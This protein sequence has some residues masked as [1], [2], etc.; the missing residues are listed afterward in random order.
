[1][2]TVTLLEALVDQGHL[3]LHGAVRAPV[4]AVPYESDAGPK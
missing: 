3:V 4:T 1:M 2:H